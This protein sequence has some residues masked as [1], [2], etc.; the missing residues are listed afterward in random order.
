LQEE[1]SL[2]WHSAR[3]GSLR[4]TVGAYRTALDLGYTYIDT[5][6]S[7]GPGVSEAIIGDVIGNS[8]DVL[9][10]TKVGMLRPAADEWGV[11]GHPQYLR[12]QVHNSL[13]RLQRDRIDVVYLHRIDPNYPLADQLGAL[14]A[15]RDEGLIGSIGISE[16]TQDQL[17][18]ILRIET[19]AVVQ[20][21]Y[22]LVERKNEPV[23]EQLEKL[24]IPFA[25]Y[26]PLLGRGVSRETYTAIHRQLQPIAA[27]HESTTHGLALAWIWERYPLSIAVT[28]SRNVSHL[29]A[30]RQ[31]EKLTLSVVALEAISAAVDRALESNEA[32][33]FNPAVSKGD[34]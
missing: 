17:D 16:P 15:L 20:S 24:S 22:N 13:L 10:A 28:G 27:D 33:P 2:A 12:Q 4:E 14:Q 32:T 31:A 3:R 34:Q 23:I 1:L 8:D 29:A 21:V 6:D 30:N 19:P 7:L 18:Q 9:V 25:A 26:W 5:A 11:L